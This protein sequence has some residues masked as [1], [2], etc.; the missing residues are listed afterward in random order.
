MKI[1]I[2]E[3]YLSANPIIYGYRFI[4]N[5]TKVPEKFQFTLEVH[6]GPVEKYSADLFSGTLAST[7][8]LTSELQNKTILYGRKY[9][10]V[11][12]F[13]YENI[14][15]ELNNLISKIDGDNWEECVSKLRI[16]FTWEYE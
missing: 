12:S 10:I 8:Y 11:E 16:Y 14:V 9:F 1:E 6:I 3:I 15:D 5:Q 4:E 13:D 2:K 7:S